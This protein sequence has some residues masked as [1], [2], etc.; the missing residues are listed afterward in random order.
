MM[1]IHR[2]RLGSESG[3]NMSRHP[4][5]CRLL[6]V[7]SLSLLLPH[8]A[9]AQ[10]RVKFEALTHDFGHQ[11]PGPVY[12]TTFKFRNVGTAPLKILNVETACGCTVGT[13]PKEEIPPQGTAELP[14]TFASR[15]RSGLFAG[16]IVVT[17][18][19]PEQPEARLT[20]TIN[21]NTEVKV[22]EDDLQ[23]PGVL[24]GERKENTRLEVEY[25]GTGD[26]QITKVESSAPFITT[27]VTKI[28]EWPKKGYKVHVRIEPT[29]PVGVSREKIRIH[30]NIPSLAPAEV[31]IIVQVVGDIK[32]TP[33]VVQLSEM[34]PRRTINVGR[35][36]PG[37]L[38]V[39]KAECDL[40]CVAAEIQWDEKEKKHR[41][42]AKLVSTPGAGDTQGKLTI[43]TDDPE[44]PVVTLNVYIS[45]VG[46]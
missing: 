24:R 36:A 38:K 15:G 21:L 27:E 44:L 17:T 43:H 34:T 28:K 12:S 22:S 14:V 46:K 26:F 3:A 45:A 10:P 31:P 30:T 41:V 37:G 5:V 42:I 1:P 29:A 40:K 33:N 8:V 6:A 23:F 13:P 2:D 18:N 32:V 25:S 35:S 4:S 11:A 7:A 20:F 9:E 19:D 16:S 39:V